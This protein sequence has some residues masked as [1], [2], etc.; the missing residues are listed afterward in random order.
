[1]TPYTYM[2]RFQDFPPVNYY[3]YDSVDLISS[4]LG[5][6]YPHRQYPPSALEE[7]SGR[8]K[9]VRSRKGKSTIS[10]KT[11]GKPLELFYVYSFWFSNVYH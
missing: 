1:M 9:T 11:K 2:L 8:P 4:G 3:D 7:K 10:K 6:D 5:Y